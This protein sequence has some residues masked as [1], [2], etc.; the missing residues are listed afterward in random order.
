LLFIAVCNS[1]NLCPATSGKCRKHA[2]LVTFSS[3][4]KTA[5]QAS[6]NRA[7]SLAAS[8]GW[9][10][11]RFTKNGNLVSL[12]GLNTMGFPV[13]LITHNNTTSAATT[14]TNTVQPGGSLGLNLSGSSTFLNDKLAIW[15]GGSV[16]AAHQE[17]AGKNI[18]IKDGASILDHTTH[19]AG[20]MIAKGVYAPAKGMAFNAATLQSYDFNS[21]I[22][23]MSAAASG[24][25]LSNHS[26]G[27]EAGWNFN[28]TDNRWEW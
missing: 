11:Q 6:H 8:R 23:E 25:L 1:P 18:A 3:Q 9:R 2:A 24:L 17:F 14:G 13:Y 16:Y 4:S 5:Y 10:V 15:D 20:T 27:D 12:Q 26:Y 7:L 22:T 21:D 28:D 19:V